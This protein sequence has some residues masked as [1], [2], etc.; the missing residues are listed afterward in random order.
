VPGGFLGTLVS[1]SPMPAMIITQADGQFLLQNRIGQPATFV[2]YRNETAGGYEAWDG[3]SM[4]TPHVAGVAALV[5]SHY[6]TKTNVQVRNALNAS[7]EDLG[8]A[9]RDTSF[10]Y[11]L[12]RAKAALDVLSGAVE[13]PPPPPVVNISLSAVR[14][15]KRVDLSWSPSGQGSVD[16]YRGQLVIVTTANDG[17]QTDTIAGKGTYAYKVCTAGSTTNCSNVVTIVF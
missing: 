9:G 10:G 7:A 3:T 8:L 4:A 16:I 5:W 1:P 12:V 17:S 6:P 14:R 13:P 15:G 11:G 2:S